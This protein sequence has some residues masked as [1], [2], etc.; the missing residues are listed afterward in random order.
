[1]QN[2]GWVY[3]YQGRYHDAQRLFTKCLQISQRVSGV[4]LQ[5]GT[6]NALAS[7]NYHLGNYKE[8]I[9][10]REKIIQIV[11]LRKLGEEDVPRIP[12]WKCNL[13][14]AYA[15]QGRY[16]EAEQLYLE[17]L[18]IIRQTWGADSR[19]LYPTTSLA[20]M[21][22]DQG[23]YDKA[24]TLLVKTL[25]TMRE[26]L[27]DEHFDTLESM[28]SLAQV[29]TAQ[30][31]FEEAENLFTETLEIA[32]RKLGEEH[33]DTLTYIKGLAVLRR[34]QKRYEDAESLFTTAL[35]G[36]RRR[37]GDDHP[38]TLQSM[39][40]LSVLYK[41]KGDYS[42][43][44]PLLLKAIEGRRLKLGAKPGASQKRPKNGEQSY[45]K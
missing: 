26:V 40:E 9:S 3:Q 42:K 28:F 19:W 39:H 38:H 8:A 20:N 43:E 14:R 24:K 22:I 13:A 6:M 33:P 32:P 4:E 21:Y 30:G 41:E 15:A 23:R 7:A 16:E 35:E 31:H 10:L 17:N 37:L 25:R 12:F 2:L 5:L 27:G 11:R 36:M 34:E 45:C 1:M 44:E 29:Y 18:E